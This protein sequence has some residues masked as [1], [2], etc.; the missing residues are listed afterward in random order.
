M[1]QTQPASADDR[2]G[3]CGVADPMPQCRCKQYES[4][5]SGVEHCTAHEP[6]FAPLC[7]GALCAAGQDGAETADDAIRY[8]DH[9]GES[10]PTPSYMHTYI[11]LKVKLLNMSLCQSRTCMLGERGVAPYILNLATR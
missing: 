10:F 11:C 2:P 1:F 9:T 7:K 4:L 5:H 8:L 3:A 6:V